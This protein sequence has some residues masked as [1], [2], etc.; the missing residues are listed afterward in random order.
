MKFNRIILNDSLDLVLSSLCL[1]EN[2]STK[3]VLL[4]LFKWKIKKKRK[5]PWLSVNI[6]FIFVPN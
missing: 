6:C 3:K 5:T 1:H 2:L 4:I